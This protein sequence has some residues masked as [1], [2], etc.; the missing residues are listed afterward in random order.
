[1]KKVLVRDNIKLKKSQFNQIDEKITAALLN[2]F[3]TETI[4]WATLLYF[5]GLKILSSRYS[6][7]V[8]TFSADVHCFY[9]IATELKTS[10]TLST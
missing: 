1:M 7:N 10:C 3:I 5:R 9:L 8:A 2:R 4:R 6:W